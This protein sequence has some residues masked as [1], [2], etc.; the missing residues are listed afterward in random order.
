MLGNDVSAESDDNMIFALKTVNNPEFKNIMTDA[1]D[2][3]I[4]ADITTAP[5]RP[6]TQ[7]SGFSVRKPY[8]TGARSYNELPN[9]LIL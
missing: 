4:V 1:T 9:K 3:E 8:Q 7:R 2:T 5:I 6:G